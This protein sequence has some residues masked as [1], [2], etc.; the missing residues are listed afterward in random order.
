M[1]AELGTQARAAAPF[2]SL[3]G[4]SMPSTPGG[5]SSF[6]S[7]VLVELGY[8]DQT[9]V[10]S[11]VDQSRLVGR[12]PESI[13]VDTGAISEEQLARAIAERNDLPFVDVSSFPIDHGA[14]ALIGS[15][16]ARRYRAAPIAFDQDG[17]LVVALSDPLDALA[18]SD[19]GEITKSEVRPAV[20]TDAGIDALL[21]TMLPSLAEPVA[22]EE[23]ADAQD[24]AW[25]LDQAI[26]T[27][28]P[29]PMHEAEEPPAP[30]P[31]PQPERRDDEIP[32]LDRILDELAAVEEAT[33][34]AA[35]QRSEPA[36]AEPAAEEPT[37][38]DN[39]PEAAAFEPLP[40]PE[41]ISFGEPD[42]AAEAAESDTTALEPLP[43]PEP[44][45]FGEPETETESETEAE[46]PP[47]A[48]S[49]PEAELVEAFEIELEPA[50][51][52]EPEAETETEPPPAAFAVPEAELVEA[53]E[54][55]LDAEERVDAPIE[56]EQVEPE[57][58]PESEPEPVVEPESI[59][60]GPR[61]VSA[62]ASEPEVEPEPEV[63]RRAGGGAR[64]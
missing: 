63:E 32:D 52:A 62:A 23:P 22:D 59:F 34:P 60:L 25:L 9:A 20:A 31:T 47:A 56:P 12:V 54:I 42:P 35:V 3:P 49:V 50:A 6:L 51:V 57:S 21:A 40:R 4:V 58:E 5:R 53:F 15:D 18:V 46:T 13:L 39:E 19:I 10:N 41:P 37:V 24:G 45:A 36:I 29:E 33:H 43:R 8:A 38:E 11:A 26:S 48:F 61:P 27:T 30:A 64:A 17:S 44:T 16:T 2:E 28:D 1:S 14:Q 7:D 55:E